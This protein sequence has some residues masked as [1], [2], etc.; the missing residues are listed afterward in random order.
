[1]AAET[2][3]NENDRKPGHPRDPSLLW[4]WSNH[5]SLHL[6][7]HPHGRLSRGEQRTGALWNTP[8]AQ[9]YDGP[10]GAQGDGKQEYAARTSM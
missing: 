5:G 4:P 6:A 8:H 9:V 7:R 1:M 10:A 2:L 3:Q